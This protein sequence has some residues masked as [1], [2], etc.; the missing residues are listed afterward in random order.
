ME[1][2]RRQIAS[3]ATELTGTIRVTSTEG[4]AYLVLT[5]LLE[6][7]HARHPSLKVD[8]ILTDRMLDLT[9]G[10]ADVALRAGPLPGQRAGRT[11]DQRRELG[12][13][14]QRAAMR[15]AMGGLQSGAG[16]RLGMR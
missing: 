9:K 5:P 14:C 3:A 15:N 12:P 7:F 8:V 10:E 1:A 16:P 6:K 2:F 4:I 11:Q 13:L